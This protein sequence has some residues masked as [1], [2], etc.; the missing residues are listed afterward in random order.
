METKRAHAAVLALTFVLGGCATEVQQTS[1]PVAPTQP[2]GVASPSEQDATAILKT[3][4][5]AWR[6]AEEMPLANPVTLGVWVGGEAHTIVLSNEGGYYASGAPETFVWGFDT[7]LATLRRLDERSMNAL[8]AMG[9]AR[10]SDPIPL[11]PRLPDGFDDGSRLRSFYIPLT[12][13]FWNRAWPET[14]PF[15]EG[16]TRRVHGADATVLIYDEGL[17]SAWYQ[18]KPTTHINADPADQV[19]DF[20][21]AIIVTRGEFGGRLNGT[22]RTFRAGETVLIPAGVR[23]EFYAGENQYGEFIILMY[24]DGA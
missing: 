8:T 17:R 11:S 13:K 5:E 12:L 1:L 7:D 3:F 4:A 2:A 20:A 9:Q 16:V 18:V 15:G 10:A 22:E 24:G 23:H 6:G 21:T 14:I 19:N